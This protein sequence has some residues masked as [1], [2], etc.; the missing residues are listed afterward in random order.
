MFPFE[1]LFSESQFFEWSGNRSCAD[2]CSETAN[3]KAPLTGA[4]LASLYNRPPNQ[5]MTDMMGNMNL[6]GNHL[7]GGAQTMGGGMGMGAM[8]GMGVGSGIDM[9]IMGGGTMPN[10]GMGGGMEMGGFRGGGMGIG[11]SGIGGEIRGG[12]DMQSNIMSG[13]MGFGGNPIGFGNV[14][15][16]R[17][18]IYISSPQHQQQKRGQSDDPFGGSLLDAPAG[19]PHDLNTLLIAGRTPCML[20]ARVISAT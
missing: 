15:S 8:G 19:A 2:S 7:M 16:D 9:G 1:Q 11:G 10:R 13:G 6:G 4:S 20:L 3:Q 12:L 5:G 17:Q 14:S 18:G